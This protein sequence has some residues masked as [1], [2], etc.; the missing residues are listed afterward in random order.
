MP[1]HTNPD[2]ELLR[3]KRKAMEI[4]GAVEADS[5]TVVVPD[6][7]GAHNLDHVVTHHRVGGLVKQDPVWSP[8]VLHYRSIRFTALC[9]LRRS[10][11]YERRAPPV[12]T[13]K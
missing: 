7:A 3:V 8:Q 10:G 13:G 12:R 6:N 5:A 2:G 1:R 11:E 4:N 9:V